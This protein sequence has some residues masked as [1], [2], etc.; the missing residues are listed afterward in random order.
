M[1]RLIVAPRRTSRGLRLCCPDTQ[2]IA[3]RIA[4]LKPATTGKVV[5]AVHDAAACRSDGCHAGLQIVREE[6][7]DRAAGSHGIRLRESADLGTSAGILDSG[8]VRSVVV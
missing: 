1:A 6:Q 2:F 5:R 7:H 8:I 3:A 4:E